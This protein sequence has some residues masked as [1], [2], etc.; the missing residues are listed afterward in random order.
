MRVG[1]LLH[2][3]SNPKELFGRDALLDNLIKDASLKGNVNVVGARRFGKTC[4]VKCAITLL[5]S[6]DDIGVYPIY[7][8]FKTDQISGTDTCYHYMVAKLVEALYDEGLFTEKEKFGATIIEPCDDWSEIAESLKE[9]KGPRAAK[10]LEKVIKQMSLIIEKTILFVIDEY[11]YLFKSAFDSPIAFMK[12]RQL[13]SDLDAD[14]DFKYFSF[15][16]VGSTTWD[17]FC[18]EHPGSGEANTISE[19]EYVCPISFDAFK[20][21]WEAECAK[22]DPQNSERVKFL[23]ENVIFAFEKSGGVPCYGK[24]KIGKHLYK[25]GLL[26]DF[27][28]LSDLFKELTSK[29]MS[30]GEYKVLSQ[31]A[32]TPSK[33]KTSIHLTNLERKGLITKDS[34]GIYRVTIS[35]LQEFILAG[36]NDSEQV[37]SMKSTIEGLAET[38]FALIET[39]NN[40]C[41]N[42]NEGHLFTLVNDSSSLEK[43][44][45]H[46]CYTPDQFVDFANALYKIYFERTKTNRNNQRWS[47]L[48][49]NFFSTTHENGSKFAKCADLSRHI[50]GKAHERDLFNPRQGQFG[51][52][53]MLIELT[54]SHN[55]P[56]TSEDFINLQ[57]ALLTRFKDTL[58][59]ILVFLRDCK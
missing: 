50:F 39:I 9:I 23:R 49:N 27:T 5:R 3:I 47:R 26:P 8:D 12:I 38:C 36:A 18:S 48:H 30:I 35:F 57:N 24:D 33:H 31:V 14:T 34:K 15:W 43:D 17:E 10:L 19:I 13:S 51:I 16:L 58:Y 44:L 46:P 32:T 55:E 45:R 52:Q 41:K 1:F 42:M 40:Q 4:L 6:R 22:I 7:L 56:Y 25:T 2:D 59:N 53:D 37:K 54:G 20:L 28:I 11:E 21:L 29:M